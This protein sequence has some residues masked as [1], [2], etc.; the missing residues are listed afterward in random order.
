MGGKFE[1][2]KFRE[3]PFVVDI[4]FA[5]MKSRAKSKFA[6]KN[7]CENIPHAKNTCYSVQARTH[8]QQFIAKFKKLILT[9]VEKN[10]VYQDQGS[11]STP[12]CR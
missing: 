7:D 10:D 12:V 11:K 6:N 5:G 4:Y 9:V 2:A 1:V 8:T 3:I